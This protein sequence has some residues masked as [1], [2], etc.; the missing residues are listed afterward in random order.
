MLE[1]DRRR[2]QTRRY[3]EHVLRNQRVE[4]TTKWATCP[5]HTKS[6]TLNEN[7]FWT[8]TTNLYYL[9]SPDNSPSEPNLLRCLEPECNS[10][11]RTVTHRMHP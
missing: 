3:A 10:T 2:A 5:N 6:A 7:G 1:R 4:L 9:P 11:W 8:G